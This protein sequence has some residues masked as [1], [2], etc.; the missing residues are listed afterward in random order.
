[1][2]LRHWSWREESVIVK[3][4]K[5]TREQRSGGNWC[6]ESRVVRKRLKE[7]EKSMSWSPSRISVRPPSLWNS[8]LSSGFST[9]SAF[10]TSCT[11]RIEPNRSADSSS[12]MKFLSR[13]EV[14]M[15][16]SLLKVFMM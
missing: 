4:T 12:L 8:L 2:M 14:L 13:K 9:G 3:F 16:R 5:V 6:E 1:M 10:S 11:M 15:T 7:G